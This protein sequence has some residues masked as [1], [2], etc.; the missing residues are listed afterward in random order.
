[1]NNYFTGIVSQLLHYGVGDKE[2]ISIAAALFQAKLL[3]GDIRDS[4]FEPLF[5][6]ALKVKKYVNLN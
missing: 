2:G 6:S 1:M 5:R 4:N 3:I